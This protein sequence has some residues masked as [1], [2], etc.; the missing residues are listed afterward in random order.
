MQETKKSF[1]SQLQQLQQEQQLNV[2]LS[3]QS[4][5]QVADQRIQQLQQSVQDRFEQLY[6]QQ[7]S[8]KDKGLFNER[9]QAQTKELKYYVDTVMQTQTQLIGDRINLAQSKQQEAL[10]KDRQRAEQLV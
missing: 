3:K 5:S 1:D 6:K 9:L 7:D 8:E 2:Q 4:S 10:Q